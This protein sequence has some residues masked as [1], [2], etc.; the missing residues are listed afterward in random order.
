MRR[1][2]EVSPCPD[3]KRAKRI[4][5]VYAWKILGKGTHGEIFA[6]PDVDDV[7]VKRF[8][9]R[10]AS[11]YAI[12]HLKSEDPECEPVIEPISVSTN[13]EAKYQELARSAATHLTENLN[14]G[15]PRPRIP[16]LHFF[17][18][19]A[20]HC[21]VGMQR[22]YP[23]PGKRSKLIQI[24]T[25]EERRNERDPQGHYMGVAEL[26]AYLRDA[27][28]DLT[29]LKVLEDVATLYASMHF[30]AHLDA[31]DVEFVLAGTRPNDPNFAVCAIDFD[32]VQLV[33][34][35]KP[36]PYCIC[37]KIAEGQFVPHRI[38]SPQRM[39]AFLASA[40]TSSGVVPRVTSPLRTEFID[41]YMR[42]GNA[43]I[44][45][46]PPSQRR[47]TLDAPRHVVAALDALMDDL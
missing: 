34:P 38:R 1:S 33:D 10:T 19:T 5:D 8:C 29:I 15:H 28:T 16:K 35:A 22:L 20:S 17:E 39:F 47:W 44:L 4:P 27:S 2:R 13:R 41:A 12:C 40:I 23:P 36:S 25:A 46:T 31:Y 18:E 45:A 37:R 21:F 14:T 7:A 32:K 43:A 42:A 30:V 3:V 9:T 11:R 26:K 24:N 6:S